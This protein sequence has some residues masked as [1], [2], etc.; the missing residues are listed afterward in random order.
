[1][2]TEMARLARCSLMGVACLGMLSVGAC[3]KSRPGADTGGVG[4]TAAGDTAST[5]MMA[6]TTG[7]ATSSSN[8]KLSDANIVALLDEANKADS[9]SG[10]FALKKAKDPGVKAFAKMMMGEHH[11]LRAQGQAL[12]KKLNVTPQAPTDDPVAK[13]GASEMDSLNAAGSGATFDKAYIDQEVTVHKAVLDLADKAHGDA[14]N[15]QL[16]SLIEKA[17]PV[18]QKHL[19]KAEELQQKLGKATT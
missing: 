12:A 13:L 19:D 14:E 16:K 8:A 5:G 4:S 15:A 1:M 9:A 18:I 3:D 17:K 2:R 10:A 7:T 6:D 11:A